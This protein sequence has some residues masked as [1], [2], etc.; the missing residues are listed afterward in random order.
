MNVIK[1][2]RI[3]VVSII[4]LSYSCDSKQ[5]IEDENSFQIVNLL[6]NYYSKSNV[7]QPSFP[8][9][10]DNLK[11]SYSTEDSL[12]I[13]KHFHEET[14][15]KKLINISEKMFAVKEKFDFENIC[16]EDV[17]LLNSMYSLE[18]KS[19]DFSGIVLTN[20]NSFLSQKNKINEIDIKIN[21]SRI[22]F[23]KTYDK[24][25]LVLGIN[26]GKFNGF[27]TLIY[28]EKDK[29]RWVIKCDKELSI[30]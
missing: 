29:Y 3:I 13:Y 24:A 17:Q 2:N 1:F 10:P 30:T 4:L 20:S 25:M 18:E 7:L 27:S 22:A 19:F 28:L 23:N 26:F 9:P 12:R 8:P 5:N 16:N 14:I 11:Y 21:F 15:R 6:V